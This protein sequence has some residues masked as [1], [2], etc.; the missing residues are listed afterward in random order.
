MQEKTEAKLVVNVV[1]IPT[2]MAYAWIYLGFVT[3]GM[4]LYTF[5]MAGAS[6]RCREAAEGRSETSAALRL[7][8][9]RQLS[10]RA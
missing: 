4:L 8:G 1:H 9:G 7:D 2:G 5:F 10:S 3:A 6:R